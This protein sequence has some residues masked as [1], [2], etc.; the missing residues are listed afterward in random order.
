MTPTPRLTLAHSTLAVTRF[1]DTLAFYRDVLG[2]HVTNQGEAPDGT[3]LCFIS[4]D[5]NNHHQIVLVE[6]TD[7]HSHGFVLA[8]H[9]AFLEANAEAIKAAGPLISANGPTGGLW[10]VDVEDVASADAL[11]R[12]DPFWP[13]G[14]RKSVVIREWR[15]VFADGR[16]LLDLP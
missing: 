10:L 5:P 13:T 14:L 9:L 15:Q 1:E 4:Q 2:F 3:K 6:G 7:A 11:V 12:A 16:R 8:D